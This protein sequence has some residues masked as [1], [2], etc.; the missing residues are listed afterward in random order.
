MA[1]RSGNWKVLRQIDPMKDTVDCTGIYKEDYGVQLAPQDL[2][3][4]VK[5]GVETVT[6]RF[7]DQP[8]QQMRLAADREKRVRAVIVA[9]VDFA[10]L[11]ASNRL[12][13]QVLTLIGGVKTGELDLAGIQSALDNIHAGCPIQSPSTPLAS[14][15][16]EP[17]S[18][19]GAC[20]AVS[21]SRMRQQGLSITQVA[22]IC[23]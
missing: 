18:A 2:F 1:F 3:I 21:M 11:L 12:R 22:A 9:G 6:L 4:E 5:G 8:A 10:E 20:N 7:G 23:K 14:P 19:D 17:T 13:Y 16:A 15:R